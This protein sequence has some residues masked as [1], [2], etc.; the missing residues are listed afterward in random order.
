MSSMTGECV[1]SPSVSSLLMEILKQCES[2]HSV[3]CVIGSSIQVTPA[4]PDDP[5]PQP[6]DVIGYLQA[7]K[8]STAN[9]HKKLIVVDELLHFHTQAQPQ[10]WRSCGGLQRVDERHE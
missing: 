5:R 2:G 9:T 1:T 3:A 4:G 7:I 8:E 10:L 6:S